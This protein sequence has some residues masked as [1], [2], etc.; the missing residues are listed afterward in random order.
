MAA[1]GLCILGPV[2]GFVALAAPAGV[3][4]REAVVAAGL[5]PIVGSA[6]ALTLAVV[7][8]VASLLADVGAWLV[9][10]PWRNVGALSR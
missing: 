6:P 3:G 10:R 5:A 2:L 1:T 4:V 9:L 8:R 7:S